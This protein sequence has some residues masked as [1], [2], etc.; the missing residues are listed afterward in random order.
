MDQKPNKS[1]F[2]TDTH[3]GIKNIISISKMI[4]KIAITQNLIS[5]VCLVSS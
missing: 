5:N 2:E 1:S 3:H 4:N